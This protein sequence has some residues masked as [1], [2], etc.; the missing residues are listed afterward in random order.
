MEQ[1]II[2]SSFLNVVIFRKEIVI[3]IQ[4]HR[5]KLAITFYSTIYSFL[6]PKKEEISVSSVLTRDD[7]IDKLKA[8]IELDRA[9]IRFVLTYGMWNGMKKTVFFIPFFFLIHTFR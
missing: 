7:R 2:R 9:F 6:P 4:K 3:R 5:A 1:K 8:I